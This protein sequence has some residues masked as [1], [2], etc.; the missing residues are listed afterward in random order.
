MRTATATAVWAFVWL[1]ADETTS[2]ELWRSPAAKSTVPDPMYHPDPLSSGMG[3]GSTPKRF[4]G[5]KVLLGAVPRE[6]T[7]TSIDHPCSFAHWHTLSP[8]PDVGP[9]LTTGPPRNREASSPDSS[10]QESIAARLLGVA[11]APATVVFAVVVRVVAVA[12]F[13]SV[14][15][16]VVVRV[17]AVAEFA[18]VA[19][20][21]VAAV[22]V[23]VVAVAEFASVAV[24][25]V[26]VVAE[27]E[28]LAVPPHPAL[29]STNS[30][31]SAAR[32]TGRR[33]SDDDGRQRRSRVSCGT[34]RCGR[35]QQSADI[36]SCSRIRI[37]S[38]LLAWTIEISTVFVAKLLG[39]RSGPNQCR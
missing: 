34:R 27:P 12:E 1:D 35:A 9:E 39:A 2:T 16:A 6:P 14:A 30:N 31:T 7:A 18:S 37:L 33:V 24:V 17:V 36:G 3:V 29:I 32:P 28:L 38:D 13:A 25:V 11:E 10:E 22:V 21:A 19:V 26:D 20:A 5:T 23:R 4:S 8:T 15:V